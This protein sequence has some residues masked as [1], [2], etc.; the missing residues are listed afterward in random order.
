MDQ[1]Q[2][3]MTRQLWRA[4]QGD[5]EAYRQV[6][7]YCFQAYHGKLTHFY[8]KD[9]AISFEDLEST[10]FMGIWDAVAKADTRGNP[11]YFIGQ[12]G[13]WKVQSEVRSMR[14]R[15]AMV[16]QFT[17]VATAGTID[18][19]ENTVEPMDTEPDFREIVVSR[20][21]DERVVRIIA[22][23][24]LR[25]R[26]REAMDIILSGEA[27]DPSEPGFNKRLAQQMDICPQRASQLT[28]DLRRVYE[29]AA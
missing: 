11:L 27:G 12:C 21:D 16:S 14:R 9:P 13:M 8:S 18:E 17:H 2:T 3:S 26:Q 25:D 10:F 22:N 4:Q 23:A 1:E 20:L 5:G 15:M 19:D 29:S 28:A 7:M 6:A 24:N